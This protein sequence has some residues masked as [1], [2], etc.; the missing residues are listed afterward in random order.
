ML[1]ADLTL[2]AKTS[3]TSVASGSVLNYMAVRG[4]L[5]EGFFLYEMFKFNS[6]DIADQSEL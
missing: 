1:T 5:L 6:A 2:L 3:V 4:V